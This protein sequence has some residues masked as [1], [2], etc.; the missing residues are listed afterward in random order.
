MTDKQAYI[1]K[2][3]VSCPFCAAESI[4][5]GFVEI[6]AGKAFQDM[7]CAECG[8]EWQDVYQLV[9]VIPIKGGDKYE[10]GIGYSQ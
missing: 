1:K 7:H 4:H 2:K 8:K 10:A 3:G 5:G 6:E 9:N